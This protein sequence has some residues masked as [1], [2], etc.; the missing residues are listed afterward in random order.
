MACGERSVVETR[1]MCSICRGR[2]EGSEEGRE[3]GREGRGRGGMG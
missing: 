2:E 3:G 1:T